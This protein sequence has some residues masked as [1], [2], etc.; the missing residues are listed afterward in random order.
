MYVQNFYYKIKELWKILN[1]FIFEFDINKEG[2]VWQKNI[3]Y[4][5]RGYEIAC[6]YGISLLPDRY[7]YSSNWHKAMHIACANLALLGGM[8][9]N[10]N[11]SQGWVPLAS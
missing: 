9:R 5:V 10:F 8:H 4:I 2:L 3:S 7:M 1:R 6:L 11:H